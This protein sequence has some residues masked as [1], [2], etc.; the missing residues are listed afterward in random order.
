MNIDNI[1]FRH[2]V[3]SILIEYRNKHSLTQKDLADYFKVSYQTISKWEREIVFPSAE[4]LILLSKLTGYSID[5]IIN[6]NEMLEGYVYVKD[7]I[8]DANKIFLSSDKEPN[9]KDRVYKINIQSRKRSSNFGKY[10][11]RIFDLEKVYKRY[12]NFEFYTN[13]KEF[14]IE[15]RTVTSK[16]IST[17]NVFESDHFLQYKVNYLS[18]KILIENANLRVIKTN[19][20]IRNAIIFTI[21]I[22]FLISIVI[23]A[24]LT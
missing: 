8:N 1:D 22:L 14:D 17:V 4:S 2:N 3:A 24:V 11:L 6:Q 15:L 20:D 21:T 7:V 18:D 13:I 5:Q 19:S 10:K 9:L 23:F 12:V 16:N